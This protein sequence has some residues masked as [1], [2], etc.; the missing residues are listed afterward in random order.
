MADLALVELTTDCWVMANS[1][2][3][4]EGNAAETLIYLT[5]G[6]CLSCVGMKPADVLEKLRAA[7][8]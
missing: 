7:L 5:G 6:G 1:V 3:A 8:Q 4:V 2:I